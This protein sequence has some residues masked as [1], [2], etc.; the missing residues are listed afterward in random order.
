FVY[1]DGNVSQV[2]R[3]FSSVDVA[4]SKEQQQ[5]QQRG[6]ASASHQHP[7]ASLVPPPSLSPP[8]VLTAAQQE[9]LREQ[10]QQQQQQQ[11]WRRSEN[12]GG[13][14]AAVSGLHH[15]G[16]GCGGGVQHDKAR[17]LALPPSPSRHRIQAQPLA[18]APP[19]GLRLQ[20][21]GLADAPISAPVTPIMVYAYPHGYMMA[22]PIA[23]P[24]HGQARRQSAHYG[25]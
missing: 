17:E 24:P 16:A 10:Q 8:P 25:Q 15:H 7:S 12:V 4:Q 1:V 6:R 11:Q 18:T 20:M 23:K 3:H 2:P 5:Q 13:V 22:Y 14:D 19:A 21:C 9:H